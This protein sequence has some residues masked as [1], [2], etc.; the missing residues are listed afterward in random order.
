MC[1]HAPAAGGMIA[2]NARNVTLV[3]TGKQRNYYVCN[4]YVLPEVAHP[5]FLWRDALES[6]RDQPVSRCVAG[7]DA[8]ARRCHHA[9]GADPMV[10]ALMSTHRA[11]RA[12]DGLCD[13]TAVLNG[14]HSQE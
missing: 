1:S 9:R 5:G 13:R 2:L 4:D 11:S 14:L 12:G 3:Q 10:E 8:M 6:L 7:D